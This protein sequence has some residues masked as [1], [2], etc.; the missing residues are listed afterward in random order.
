MSIFCLYNI[1]LFTNELPSK[2][3]KTKKTPPKWKR[4]FSHLPSIHSLLLDLTWYTHKTEMETG[5]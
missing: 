4:I 3:K 1:G 2:K 5:L